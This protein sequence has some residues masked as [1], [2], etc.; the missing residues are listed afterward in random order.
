MF[1]KTAT[2]KKNVPKKLR[3]G[4]ILKKSHWNAYSRLLLRNCI[5]KN[6]ECLLHIVHWWQVY[7]SLFGKNLAYI[8]WFDLVSS[9]EEKVGLGS[10]FLHWNQNPKFWV[11]WHISETKTN[12]VFTFLF[13]NDE[14]DQNTNFPKLP[15]AKLL[16]LV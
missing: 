13:L 9:T 14:I 10:H 2:Y 7:F 12:Q 16:Y 5:E 4:L 1:Q 15:S 6:K 8:I 11:T 3:S